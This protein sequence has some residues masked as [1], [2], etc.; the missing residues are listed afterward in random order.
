VSAGRGHGGRRARRGGHHEEEHENHERWLVSY[1]DMVT[2]L[3]ALFLILFAMSNVDKVK[4]ALLAQGIAEGFGQPEYV[5]LDG[6]DGILEAGDAQVDAVTFDALSLAV[7]AT[8]PG[9]LEM[10]TVGGDPLAS[11]EARD[12]RVAEARAEAARLQAIAEQTQ[13]S[14]EAAGLPQSAEYRIDE[15]GL[16]IA[17]LADNLLFADASAELQPAGRAIVDA[18][19]PVL[20]SV[21]QPV[22]VEGHANRLPLRPG[23]PYPSN[24]EL[25]AARAASVVRH[26]IE[27]NGLDPGRLSAVG[28]ADT[29]PFVPP[30]DPTSIVRNRRVDIVVVSEEPTEV[31]ALLPEVAASV[32]LPGA[33]AR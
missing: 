1:A 28:Y 26:L 12:R 10:I 6:G 17:L 9:D 18:V 7:P 27:D 30:D 2:L 14:L 31:R 3:M 19:S 21:D 22:D 13:A 5:P 25:S 32:P 11:T 4:A 20:R 29:R 16:V 24:W 15:R 8:D 23:A 33:A